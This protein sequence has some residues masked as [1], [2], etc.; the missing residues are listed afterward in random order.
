MSLIVK[1]PI[2]AV[3]AVVGVLLLKIIPGFEVS[4]RGQIAAYAVLFGVAQETVTRLIDR[5]AQSVL[6]SVSSP[7][8]SEAATSTDQAE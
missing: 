5:R 4:D 6:D 7:S 2:G 1:L 8:R 3:I